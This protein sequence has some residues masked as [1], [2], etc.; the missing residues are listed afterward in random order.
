MKISHVSPLA[1]LWS[2]ETS[3]PFTLL[4]MQRWPTSVWTAY[5]KSTGVDPTGSVITRPLGVNTK[6]S[7]CSRSVF[8][9]SM[10][11][12]GSLTSACQSMMRLSQSMSDVLPS[13]LYAQC[14]ATPHS[15]RWCISRVRIC[16]S[17]GRPCGPITVVCRLW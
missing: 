4:P 12:A 1:S 3:R 6:T 13:P 11:C 14:A 5:A 15:A 16:T 2:S 8:R 7:S 9:F 10:N 17:I